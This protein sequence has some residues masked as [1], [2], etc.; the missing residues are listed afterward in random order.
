MKLVNPFFKNISCRL[1]HLLTGDVS[2]VEIFI[3]RFMVSPHHKN[4]LEP[5][6]PQSAQRLVMAMAFIPL[7]PVVELGP[8]TVVDRDKRK[9]VH[10]VAQ[11][12]VTGETEVDDTT[13]AAGFS[14]RHRSRLGLKVARRL[15]ATR[16]VTELGPDRRRLRGGLAGAGGGHG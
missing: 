14:H 2:Q 1:T 11:M 13:F 4:N 16:S 7:S 12:L 3:V 6:S 5:L 9:P 8:L 10:G 15:P